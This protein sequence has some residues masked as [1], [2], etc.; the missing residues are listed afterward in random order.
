V[1]LAH[2]FMAYYEMFTRDSER[3]AEGLERIDVMPLGSAALAGTPYNIDREFTAYRLGFKKI[4]ANSMDAVSDRDFI[5]EFLSSASICMMHFSR[6]SEELILWSSSEFGFIEISDAFTT[7]SSIMPQ[8]K[9]PDVPEL[10]RGKFGR[11]LGSLVSLLTLMKSLPLAYNRDMQEDK[12]PLF[13]TIDTLKSCIQIYTRMVPRIKPE[14]GIMHKAASAGYL[15]ATDLADYLV[16]KGMPFRK[17]HHCAGNA[18][19]YAISR[20]KEL[21]ELGLD[22]LRQFSD[23]IS[24]D[25]YASLEPL[26]VI[27]KRLSHGGTATQ[28]VTRSIDNA[29]EIL[30]REELEGEN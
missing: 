11:V 14:A 26:A 10:V 15:N 28:N 29:I 4:S 21:N 25:I 6:I 30:Q 20:N 12:E 7:G 27:N 23:L 2:H 1:L 18:V 22:E 5:I 13:D 17:A 3:F 9:N 19:G 16:M 24:D 8:K